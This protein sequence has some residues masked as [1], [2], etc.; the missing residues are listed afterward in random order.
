[1]RQRHRNFVLPSAEDDEVYP[2][3]ESPDLPSLILPG[4]PHTLS[5]AH[6]NLNH[7][8]PDND[9]VVHQSDRDSVSTRWG[10]FIRESSGSEASRVPPP[11]PLPQIPAPT[12][13]AMGSRH[14]VQ[15]RSPDDAHNPGLPSANVGKRRSNTLVLAGRFRFGSRNQ[16]RGVEEMPRAATDE[17]VAPSEPR[18]SHPQGLG[19]SGG[20]N[21]QSVPREEFENLVVEERVHPWVAHPVRAY[22]R[23]D[24]HDGHSPVNE[25]SGVDMASRSADVGR[26][27][28]AGTPSPIQKSLPEVQP[29]RVPQ[30]RNKKT[31]NLRLT[32]SGLADEAAEEEIRPLVPLKAGRNSPS[33]ISSMPVTPRDRADLQASEPLAPG[34]MQMKGPTSPQ[35]SDAASIGSSHRKTISTIERDFQSAMGGV[36]SPEQPSRRVTTQPVGTRELDTPPLS[37]DSEVASGSWTPT[38]INRPR[39]LPAPATPTT[40]STKATTRKPLTNQAQANHATGLTPASSIKELPPTPDVDPDDLI[41]CLKGQLDS[42]RKQRHDLER[43]T[44]GMRQRLMPRPHGDDPL[45]RAD[46]E[47]TIKECITERDGMKQQEHE[48]EMRIH[49]AWKRRDRDGPYQAPSLWVRRATSG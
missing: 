12:H 1:M 8:N 42:I 6:Q 33:R 11:P 25:A 17:E 16:R 5:I 22:G 28:L 43:F 13:P 10:D 3:E 9:H 48:I 19:L 37:A 31:S 46:I 26:R 7:T 18:P 34:Y 20:S 29:L 23:R 27:M 49:R 44:D 2:S 24:L 35:S 38:V 4:R 45:C 36:Y 14:P 39:P 15:T 40:P 21:A 47:N 41:L 30:E 32:T